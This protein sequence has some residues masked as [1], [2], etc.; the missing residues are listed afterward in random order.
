MAPR[1]RF[2]KD[3]YATLGLPP[4]A[5]ED[6]IRRAYRRL[7]LQWHP[8]RN[9]GDAGAAERFKAISE[10][11]AV[12][13]D[14]GKRQDYDRARQVGTPGSFRHRR[15]DIFRDLFADPRA[16]GVFEDL[17]REFERVG[18]RVDRRV[19]QQTLFGGRAVVT[20]G[21]FVA[22]PLT[23]GAGLLT[24]LRTALRGAHA[25]HTQAKPQPLEPSRGFL[26]RLADAGRSLLG[27]TG[28]AAEPAPNGRDLTLQMRLTRAEAQRGGQKRLT[29]EREGRRDELLVTIPSGIRAG[30]RLRLR[31]KGRRLTGGPPG[32]LYLAIDVAD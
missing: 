5:T 21:V 10:A 26:G 2:D 20:G 13:I 17:V 4:A 3:Y 30:T 15:E 22:T 1:A 27:L 9:A 19:F 12:L 14:P 29:V 31:G 18:V 24:V 28:A 7:A 11:Y 32:D 6:D 25:L 8:D 16:S 23:S